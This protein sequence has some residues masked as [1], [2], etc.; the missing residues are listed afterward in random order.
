MFHRPLYLFICVSLFA[1]CNSER[2]STL[3]TEVDSTH[4]N[5]V[6]ANRV[7]QS[8]DNNVMAY[9]YY[10]NGGGVAVGDINNDGLVDVYFTGN[11]VPNKLYLNSGSLVFEDITEKAGVAAPIGWKT[12]VTMADVNQDGWLD[13]YVCR[14]AMGDSTLREN[15]LYVN[16]KN[17]TFTERGREYGIAD[18][19][20]STQAAF[21]DYD[22]DDDLDLFVLNHSLP[23]Y[24]GFNRLLANHKAERSSKFGSKIFRN[25]KGVFVDATDNAGLVNNVLSFGLGLAVSDINGDGWLD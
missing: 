19:S 12:G 2:P 13:I 17:L 15:L 8:G 14:S 7:V 10:F 4:S 9:P 25:E 6:F 24:A 1:A 20:Y 5:I 3:F 16:N 11:Q 23:Q 21:F 18:N 22:N